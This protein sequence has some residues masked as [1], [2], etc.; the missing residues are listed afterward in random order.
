MIVFTYLCLNIFI[1]Y[2]YDFCIQFLTDSAFKTCEERHGP[3]A[4]LPCSPSPPRPPSSSSSSSSSSSPLSF[5][6][7]KRPGK[8]AED[9]KEGY[10]SHLIDLTMGQVCVCVLCVRCVR[11]REPDVLLN[12]SNFSQKQT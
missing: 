10:L 1:L 12:R 7:T 5:P 3:I 11:V 2:F 9:K 6:P 8:G 4:I